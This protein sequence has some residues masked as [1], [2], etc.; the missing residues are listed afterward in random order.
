MDNTDNKLAERIYQKR[1]EMG[2]TMKE[3]GDKVGVQH[4]A[5]NKWEKGIV[6]NIK[7]ETI[8]K[9]S[10]IFNVSPIWLMGWDED[11]NKPNTDMVALLLDRYPEVFD[12][13][14]ILEY[15]KMDLRLKSI[16]RNY[17]RF[18]ISEEKKNP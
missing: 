9:L 8:K 6:Q 7:A 11:A 10:E 3:L 1:I 17:A 5:V 16:V 14:F 15:A 2:L 18:L 4:S 13:P 12:D